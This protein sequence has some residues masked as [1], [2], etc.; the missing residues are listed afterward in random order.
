M[1]LNPIICEKCGKKM[2]PEHIGIDI[3]R[4]DTD[5]NDLFVDIVEKQYHII[6]ICYFCGNKVNIEEEKK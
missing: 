4:I 3:D 5:G 6:R 1:I 2:Q